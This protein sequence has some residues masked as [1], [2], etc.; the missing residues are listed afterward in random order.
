MQHQN[1]TYNYFHDVD[2]SCLAAIEYVIRI[3]GREKW[4]NAALFKVITDL[5]SI[6]RKEICQIPFVIILTD[7]KLTYKGHHYIIY[8]VEQYNNRY[9]HK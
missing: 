7:N 3:Y 9:K 5:Y 6:P 2:T 1:I 4:F 8:K